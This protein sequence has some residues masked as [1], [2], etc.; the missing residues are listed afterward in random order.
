MNWSGYLYIYPENLKAKAT[1]WLWELRDLAVIGTSL[2][3]SAL[4]LAVL[5]NFVPFVFAAAYAFL[6]IRHEGFS[7]LDFLRYGVA[8]FLTKPQAYEWGLE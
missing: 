7:V 2:L 1:L 8:Y 6:S 5:H 4:V 3:I